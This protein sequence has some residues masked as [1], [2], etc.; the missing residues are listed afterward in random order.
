MPLKYKSTQI[1]RHLLL[2]CSYLSRWDRHVAAARSRR[3]TLVTCLIVVFPSSGFA[4]HLVLY[5]APPTQEFR[6]Q[7]SDLATK[8]EKI[9]PGLFHFEFVPFQRH[10]HLMSIDDI[11]NQITPLLIRKPLALVTG[12]LD[13]AKA[14]TQKKLNIQVI[15][16][17]LADPVGHGVI[18]SGTTQKVDITGYSRF[19]M[20]IDEKRLSILQEIAPRSRRVGLLLD[21]YIKQQRVVGKGGV[22]KYV[23]DGLEVVPF[24][25]SSVDE[26]VA[27]IKSSRTLGIDSWY[28]RLM[29]ANYE[30]ENAQKMVNA[31][32][33]QN[34]PAIY[35]SMRF[36]RFGGLIAYQQ[37][38][39]EPEHI[40]VRDLL[41]LAEGVRARQ[42]PFERP[43]HFYTSLN[44][45]AAKRLNI[46]LPAQLMRRVDIVFPCTVRS[47]LDCESPSPQVY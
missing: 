26:A 33:A 40:W 1:L 36:V 5:V 17:A 34:L 4:Q 27:L 19:I 11:A 30:D 29:V 38:I 21:E 31:V 3:A 32:S 23:V 37:V 39:L 14:V 22:F 18:S 13:I 6:E 8:T 45:D 46:K 15:V 44:T 41:L 7:F 25:I 35:D 12:S 10:T 24:V 9:R 16:S 28:V 43:R 20:E 42:V 47:P 2:V